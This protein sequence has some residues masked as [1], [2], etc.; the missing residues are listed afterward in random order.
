ML[1]LI[2]LFLIAVRISLFIIIMESLHLLVKSAFSTSLPLGFGLCA[3]IIALCFSVA[4]IVDG[5]LV[6]R[7]GRPG[8]LPWTRRDRA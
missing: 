5:R 2:N 6:L 3:L 7:R 8:W 1:I 4:A